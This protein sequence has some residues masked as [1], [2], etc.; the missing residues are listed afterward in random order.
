MSD[1]VLHSN[2]ANA[3]GRKHF[4]LLRCFGEFCQDIKRDDVQFW[5]VLWITEL[6]QQ[7]EDDASMT[8]CS[9]S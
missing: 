3:N 1:N 9:G 6:E 4:I 8:D 5:V 2:P 7:I